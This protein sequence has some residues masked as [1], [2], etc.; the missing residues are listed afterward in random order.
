MPFTVKTRTGV[1]A[2][3]SVAH[4]L[5]PKLEQWGAAAVTLHGRSR[6]QRYTKLADW[7]YIEKCAANV[8]NIPVIG[9]GDILNF[10]D[11]QRVKENSPHVSSVMIGR[12]ALIK[13]WFV[14]QV[15]LFYLK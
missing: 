13:P 9:N 2:D 15:K 6:E 5:L 11:Y 1:Q 4:E 12:G 3:K 8:K 14:I 7:E 10:E